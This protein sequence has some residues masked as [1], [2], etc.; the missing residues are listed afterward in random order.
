MLRDGDT[1]L[2]RQAALSQSRTRRKKLAVASIDIRP[3]EEALACSTLSHNAPVTLEESLRAYS[4]LRVMLRNETPAV[5]ST[6][7]A[8]VSESPD[9][10]VPASDEDSQ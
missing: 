9:G 7:T 6:L 4:E 10:D 8:A 2:S 1:Q 3:D 5:P